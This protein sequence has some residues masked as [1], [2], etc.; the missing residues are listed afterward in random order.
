[1]PS[2]CRASFG[3]SLSRKAAASSSATRNEPAR[4]AASSRISATARAAP[5]SRPPRVQSTL[6]SVRKNTENVT[7]AAS[8]RHNAVVLLYVDPT[9]RHTTASWSRP[10]DVL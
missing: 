8:V 6:R 3:W 2:T 7:Y 1:M 4:A 10:R 5:K 9:V